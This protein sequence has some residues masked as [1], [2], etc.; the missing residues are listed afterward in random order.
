MSV[1]CDRFSRESREQHNGGHG[2][3]DADRKQDKLTG[4]IA[5]VSGSDCFQFRLTR[6][7][8][9][10]EKQETGQTTDNT[11]DH[12]GSKRNRRQA[13]QIVCQ[14]EWDRAETEQDHNFPPF[15][16]YRGIDGTE[17]RTF[18]QPRGYLIA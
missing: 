5:G 3:G 11:R 9:L 15:L 17:C 6:A 8:K 16:F 2:R 18:P 14:A 12:V 13:I 1:F 7:T 10:A 4:T